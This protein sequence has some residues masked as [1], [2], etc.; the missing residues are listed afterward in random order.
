[1]LNKL[2]DILRSVISYKTPA[3][4]E[5]VATI[6]G[7]EGDYLVVNLNGEEVLIPTR[8]LLESEQEI[9]EIDV[10]IGEKHE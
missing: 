8:E 5:I 1:M 2:K 10:I 3:D 7:T 4:Q 6:I 9:E